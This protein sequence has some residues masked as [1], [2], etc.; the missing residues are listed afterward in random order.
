[1]RQRYTLFP[2]RQVW[3]LILDL[4]SRILITITFMINCTIEN[5]QTPLIRMLHRRLGWTP[6]E[7]WS[8]G[9]QSLRALQ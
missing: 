7:R 9:L 5:P 1:M 6:L 2:V 4:D 3:S 8:C